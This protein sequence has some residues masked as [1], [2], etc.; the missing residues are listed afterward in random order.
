VSLTSELA[1]LSSPLARYLA[2]RFPHRSAIA[3]AYA[4]AVSDAPT[5]TPAAGGRYPWALVGS[6]FGHRLGFAF[7][8]DPPYAPLLGASQLTDTEQLAHLAAAQFATARR[9]A[10]GDVRRAGYVRVVAGDRRLVLP[11]ADDTPEL[12][13]AQWAAPDPT[14]QP[15]LEVFTQLAARVQGP[16]PPGRPRPDRRV[17]QPLLEECW[18]LACYEELHRS[19]RSPTLTSALGRLGPA[20][21]AEALLGLAPRAVRDDLWRLTTALADRGYDQLAALGGPVTVAP[22]FVQAWADGDLVLGRTLVEVKVTKQ[23]LP[24]RDEWLNQ[25]L[26]YVLLDHGDWYDLE[27]IAVFLGR[28]ARL[29][30][31]PLAELLPALTGDPRVTLA[32]LRAEFYALLEQV[33]ADDLEFPFH[34]LWVTRTPPPW[35]QS[36]SHNDF[37]AAPVEP[38]QARA[39]PPPM[40]LEQPRGV[41]ASQPSMS[42]RAGRL[43]ARLSGLLDRPRRDR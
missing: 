26:G 37:A 39:V 34:H 17:E 9:L 43:R 28:Q 15:H 27:Q 32:E 21:T 24:L 20:A 18:V 7:A 10:D 19:G 4:A 38:A 8:A 41:R 23:P 5:V 35:R 2:R 30:A 25:L 13:A 16:L 22:L 42:G 31:W 36:T 14:I 11:S 12:D 6:A 29:V 1:D 3:D 33:W 40:Q